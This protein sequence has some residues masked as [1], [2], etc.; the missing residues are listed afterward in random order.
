MIILVFLLLLYTVI[1]RILYNAKKKYIEHKQV[2][3]EKFLFG[4][5]AGKLSEKE[6]SRFNLRYGDW[7]D[8]GVFIE[9]YLVNLKGEDYEAIIQLL[10]EIGFHT[11]LMRALDKKN[12]WEK[13]YSIYFLGIMK[14]RPAEKKLIEMVY[15]TSP[16]IFMN[17]FETL[18]KIGTIKDIHNII[19]FILNSQYFIASKVT[20]IILSY[21]REINPVLLQLLAEEDISDRSKRLIVDVFAANNVVESLPIII[22]LAN[23]TDDTELKI[24]CIKATGKIGGPESTLFLSKFMSSPDWVI[25]SQ[26]VKAIGNMSSSDII[27]ELKMRILTDKNY[28]VRLY[29]AQ[30]LFGFG[31]WGKKELETLLEIHPSDDIAHIINYVLYEMEV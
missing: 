3:W 28:W 29:S 22:E 25:R 2:F 10:R 30:A 31:K 23:K 18:S 13:I 5:L 7:V 19:K 26:A 24:G 1:L 9:N 16:E 21:G 14:Y 6:L 4:Y 8:F 15:D 20:D 12:Q 27:P 11:K 17:A